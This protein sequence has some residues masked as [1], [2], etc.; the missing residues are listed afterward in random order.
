MF[1]TFRLSQIVSGPNRVEIKR[2]KN[3]VEISDNLTPVTGK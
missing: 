1:P 2:G 3:E